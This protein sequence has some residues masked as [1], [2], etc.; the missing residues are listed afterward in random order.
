MFIH[1]YKFLLSLLK[2]V[3]L[4][5]KKKKKGACIREEAAKLHAF[6]MFEPER[7]GKIK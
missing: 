5:G 3:G 2:G 7:L 4:E 6:W 1:I